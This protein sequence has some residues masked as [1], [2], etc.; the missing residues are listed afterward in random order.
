MPDFKRSNFDVK[1][2][3]LNRIALFRRYPEFVVVHHQIHFPYAPLSK[4][5]QLRLSEIAS[6]TLSLHELDLIIVTVIGQNSLDFFLRKRS[7]TRQG[8]LAHGQHRANYKK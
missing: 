6:I 1:A 3:S 8:L 7:S 2:R 4:G 5:S